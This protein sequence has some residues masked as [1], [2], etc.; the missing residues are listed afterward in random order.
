MDNTTQP[1]AQITVQNDEPETRLPD[2]KRLCLRIGLAFSVYFLCRA[3]NSA[4]SERL[5]DLLGDTLDSTALYALSAALGVILVYLVPMA[6]TIALLGG[7]GSL[8]AYYRRPQKTAKAIANF[9][10][11]YGLGQ[12]VNFLTLLAFWAIGQLSGGS[13]DTERS[14]TNISGM[15]PENVYCALIM[16]FQLVV[17]APL[18]E[19]IWT[20][21]VLYDAL[22]PYGNGLAILISSLIFGL[23]HGNLQMLFYTTALGLAFGYIRYATGSIFVTTILHAIFNSIS[24]FIL[25]FLST[26]AVN[27]GLAESESDEL[28]LALFSIYMIVVYA[29][30]FLGIIAFFR[31]LPVI[32]RY[33][34]EKNWTQLRPGRKL[35]VFLTSIPVLLMLVLAVD[36][37]LYN[38][39]AKWVYTLI[40]GSFG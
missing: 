36:S 19:E 38:Q 26:N 39:T 6:A 13:V 5:Y 7:L 28:V 15:V 17:I 2:F 10:A 25:L 40:G 8:S 9:P 31:K 29:L 32:R 37:S 16:M 18:F 27:T 4:L 33:R 35:V 21:G 14:F 22:Q 30:L 23:M 3:V 11:A 12:S 1:T 34:I 24:A 20:R